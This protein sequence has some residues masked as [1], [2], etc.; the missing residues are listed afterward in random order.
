MIPLFKVFMADEAS[1]RVGDVLK[2]GYIGQGS[3]V[4]EF[5]QRLQ[6]FLGA[7][8][9]ATVNS[10]TSAIHLALH[11]V[12]TKCPSRTKVLTIPITCT[13]TNFPILANGLEPKWVDTD[14]LTCNI[15]CVDLRR[16]VDNDTLA[17]VVVHWG[18]Y[19]CDLNAIREVQDD[20]EKWYGYRPPVIEDCAHAF[21][22]SY[23]GKLLGNHGNYCC[24]SFQA[25]KHL[26][27]GDGG[28]LSCP[29]AHS[30]DR[31]ILLRWYGLD[32]ASSTDMRCVQNVSEWGFKFHMNDI[33]ASI[34]LANLAH[35]DGILDRYRANGLYYD[36]ELAGVDGV[37]LLDYD[38]QG[39]AYWIYT[40]RVRDR[41]N[42]VKHMRSR[43]VS[44][45][46]VH[47]RNDKH[48]CMSLARG[49]LPGTDE[50][51]ADM[52]CIPCGWWVSDEDREHI[53]AS[54]KEGW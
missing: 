9:V 49:G 18:G 37:K 46:Q 3:K 26:T 31:A 32:R 22:A 4:D 30:H 48:E 21:G 39:C 13:A 33:N 51:C 42:F 27:T 38:R 2:S 29:D 43:G 41:S 11:L 8:Y 53:V 17:I 44:V 40:I 50:I 14:P 6:E 28:L 7:P 25:I 54:I 35:I 16:K 20:C 19:P 1:G 52:I 12:K 47:D 36:R 10:A 24:F 15:D 34:G 5:E 23:Y 45:S